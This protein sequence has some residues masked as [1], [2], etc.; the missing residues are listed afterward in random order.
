MATQDL[1]FSIPHNFKDDDRHFNLGAVSNETQLIELI[2]TYIG[3]YCGMLERIESWA[4]IGPN[5]HFLPYSTDGSLFRSISEHLLSIGVKCDLNQQIPNLRI[6]SDFVLAQIGLSIYSVARHQFL[7][8]R[9]QSCRMMSLSLS[10][11]SSIYRDHLSDISKAASVEIGDLLNLAYERYTLFCENTGLEV[12]R[13]RSPHPRFQI[14]N[15]TFMRALA[16][17][18]ISA[19]MGYSQ[20]PADFDPIEYLNLNPEIITDMS[21]N[22][23]EEFSLNHYRRWGFE[24][25][26]PVPKASS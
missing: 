23:P 15:E 11:E 24:E 6:S 7:F 16:D 9:T 4:K 25:V 17:T 26:R 3:K 12:N 19:K 10:L 2:R 14:M 5:F 18:L 22:S 13:D 1:L 8:S 21:V 20:A